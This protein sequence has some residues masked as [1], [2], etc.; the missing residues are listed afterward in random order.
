MEKPIQRRRCSNL[1]RN[2]FDDK[3]W[4]ISWSANDFPTLVVI[5]KQK[6]HCYRTLDRSF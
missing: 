6:V 4:A 2:L 5:L 3:P 1:A